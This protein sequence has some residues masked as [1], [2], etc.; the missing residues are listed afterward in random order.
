MATCLGAFKKLFNSD[1]NYTYDYDELG[2][3]YNDYTELMAHFDNVLPGRVHR[4]TYET[5]VADNEAEI[6]KLLAY[7]GLEFHPACLRFWESARPV[8]TAS[9]EQVRQPIFHEGLD[10]WRHFEP[11]LE[12]LKEAVLF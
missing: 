11:W 4:A 3:Y 10:R 6:R 8:T 9:S 1:Q 12:K 5:I 2:R 7:C